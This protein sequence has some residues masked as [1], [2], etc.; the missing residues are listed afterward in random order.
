MCNATFLSVGR[1][2]IFEVFSNKS[3]F[4]S[5]LRN[6]LKAIL[7]SKSSD[8]RGFPSSWECSRVMQVCEH[9]ENSPKDFWSR[10]LIFP[11]SSRNNTLIRSRNIWNTISVIQPICQANQQVVHNTVQLS[12]FA[13]YFSLTSESTPPVADFSASLPSVL[14]SEPI[15]GQWETFP[16]QCMHQQGFENI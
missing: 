2:L 13:D 3:S 16:H 9:T 15:S 7:N 10:A 4:R 5:D 8:W 1:F 6:A 14:S 11:W 12:N